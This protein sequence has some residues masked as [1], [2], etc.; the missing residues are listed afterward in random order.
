MIAATFVVIPAPMELTANLI[1]ALLDCSRVL[2]IA[3]LARACGLGERPALVAGLLYAVTPATFLLHSWGNLPTAYGMWCTLAATVY[4]AVG[5]KQLDRRRV[6]IGLIALLTVTLLVY[7]VM[8]TF[9]LVFL[10]LLVAGLWLFGERSERRSVAALALAAGAALG[11]ATLIYY[12]QYIQPIIERTIPYFLHAGDGEGVNAVRREPFGE[13]LAKYWPRMGYLRET[14]HYGLQLPLLI[15]L[16]GLPL[17]RGRRVRIML[18][19]WLAVG[20]LFLIAGSRISMVDKH[21]FYILP[22]LALGAGALLGRLWRRGRAAP[23]AIGLLFAFTLFSAL[24]M[25][26]YRVVNVQ[27]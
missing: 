16:L 2:L 25:W 17:I 18:A 8:A 11:L 21:L 10:G 26:L 5:W 20:V 6:L 15:G 27:Q 9:M 7:T 24:E 3:L 4:L 13:Y 12:G 14:G 19:S 23:L 22:A 1:S